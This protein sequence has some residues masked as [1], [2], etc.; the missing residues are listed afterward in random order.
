[1]PLVFDENLPPRLVQSLADVFPNST[2][3]REAGLKSAPDDAIWNHARQHSLAIVSKDGDFFDR[4]ILLGHPPKVIW[5]SLGNASTD[6][7]ESTLRE[8]AAAINA[9]LSDQEASVLIVP[10]RQPLR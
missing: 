5:L 3:V 9:F 2:H 7:I 1:M 4:A 6:R 8:S 10:T